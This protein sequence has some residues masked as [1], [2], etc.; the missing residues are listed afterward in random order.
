ML[1]QAEMGERGGEEGRGRAREGEGEGERE[2]CRAVAFQARAGP[3]ISTNTP[4]APVQGAAHVHKLEGEK[5]MYAPRMMSETKSRAP[6]LVIMKRLQAMMPAI[7]STM[8]EERCH[9][10]SA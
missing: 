5:P 3:P 7:E 8:R 9:F 4:R 2:D 6:M 1:K 10:F